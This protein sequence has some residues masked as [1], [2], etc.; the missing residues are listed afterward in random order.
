MTRWLAILN[1]WDFDIV[2]VA[3]KKNV[4]ADAL[5]RRLEEDGWEPPL[6]PEEDVEEFI[7]AQLSSSRLTFAESCLK[8]GLRGSPEQSCVSSR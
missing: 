5:S 2:H 6:E 3:G 7:D 1:M 4:V 8:L